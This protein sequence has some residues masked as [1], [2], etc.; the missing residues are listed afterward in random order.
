MSSFGRLRGWGDERPSPD[1]IPVADRAKT[2]TPR[3][4]R[5]QSVKS[6]L[7]AIDSLLANFQTGRV[8]KSIST[9]TGEPSS[10]SRL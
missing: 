3:S 2:F 5:A 9:L 10:V 6:T 8:H 1:Q 4:S 7:P